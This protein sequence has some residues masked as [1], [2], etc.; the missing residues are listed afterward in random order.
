M[1]ALDLAVKAGQTVAGNLS[2]KLPWELAN[3]KWAATINPVLSNPLVTGNLLQNLVL[4]TGVNTIN[5]FL[6]RKLQG[7]F[8]VINSD[9]VTFH[10]NQSNNSQADLT[11]LL[12][13]SGPATVSIYVF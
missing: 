11:L 13:A 1:V 9:P 12:V 8:V 10:D 2:A 4:K 5:H 7:Y 6:G 3:P